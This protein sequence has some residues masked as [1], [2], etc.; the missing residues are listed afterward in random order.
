ELFKNEEDCDKIL[1]YIKSEPHVEFCDEEEN[2]PF[3]KEILEKV[4]T[5]WNDNIQNMIKEIE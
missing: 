5:N 3:I 1:L 4:K 2:V